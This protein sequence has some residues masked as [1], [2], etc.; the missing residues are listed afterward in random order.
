MPHTYTHL[1]YHVVFS[2]KER[3]RLIDAD[4]RPRLLAYLGGIVREIHGV[5]DLIN[6]VEDHVHMLVRLPPTLCMSD[7]LR[8]IKANS[9]K[10][11]HETWPQRADFAW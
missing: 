7:A 5:P 9:S 4:L 10:W 11:V 6:G 3:R 8:T 1:L 2:T